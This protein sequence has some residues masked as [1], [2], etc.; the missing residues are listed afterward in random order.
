MSLGR[1]LV[2]G[3]GWSVVAC[4]GRVV[5]ERESTPDS[6]SEPLTTCAE[7]RSAFSASATLID[8]EF[9]RVCS[10]DQDCTI[11]PAQTRCIDSCLASANNVFD[12]ARALEST[13]EQCADCAAPP[14]TS[15]CQS[16]IPECRQG[17][18]TAVPFIHPR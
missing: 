16:L 17:R 13:S 3:L 2:C 9:D 14:A 1:L 8:H 5:I 4:G 18:C 10:S 11:T 6:G 7:E 15:P 12:Y